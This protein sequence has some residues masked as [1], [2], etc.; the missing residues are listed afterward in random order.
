M[1]FDYETLK[2]IWWALIGVLLIGFAVTDGF[3]LGACVLLPIL[4]RSDSERRVVINTVGPHWEG[5][6]VWF[7]TAGGAIF[8]AWPAVYAAAFSGFYWA[9]LLVLFALFFRPVGFDYRSK[10]ADPR[11]RS[12]WDWGLFIGGAVPALVFGVAFGNLLLGVPF[13]HDEFM[14]PSYDGNLFG[15]LNP[16]GL[17]CGVVSLAMLSMHG[18]VYVAL[19]SEGRVSDRARTWGQICALVTLACFALAGIW[20]SSSI[21]GYQIVSAPAHDALPNPLAKEVV[22]GDGAWLANYST[23]PATML[24]PVIGFLGLAGTFLLMGA[25]RYGFAFLTSS[26]GMAGIILTA[27]F[28][29]FPFVM[30]SSLEPNSSLTLWDASSSHLTLN[31][32]TYAAIVFVPIILFYTLWCYRSL[33]GRVSVELINKNDHTSY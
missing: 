6:Q 23:Y 1:L 5:N 12:S 24:A 15:L 22:R 19:R 30:P 9:M 11:W 32:M 26:L 8:A 18:A 27:G 13:Q 3:D 17:L 33:W 28:S 10:I 29:L 16:F 2:L 4:G 20:L 31:V 7:V 25:R 14:R 21:D